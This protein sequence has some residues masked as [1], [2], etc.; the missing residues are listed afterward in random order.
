MGVRPARVD[1][2]TASPDEVAQHMQIEAEPEVLIACPPCTGFSRTIAQNHM[3]DDPRNNLVVRVADFAQAWRPRVIV[4]ENARELVMGRFQSHLENLAARLGH[5]GYKVEAKTYFLDRFGLPQ[6]RER[7]IVVAVQKSLPLLTLSELW[8]PWEV[9]VKATHVRRAIWHL[10]ELEA[11]AV[12]LAD[13]MHASPAFSSVTARARTGAI[14]RD[15]GSWFDIPE[16]RHDLLTPTMRDRLARGQLGSH[17]DVYGRMWW[18]RPAPTIKRE[19]SHVGNGRYTH[20]DQDR[21]CSVRE[22]ALLNGFPID[23][24]FEG[25][26]SNRYRH[27]GDAVPPMIAYQLA[28]V[29]KWSLT[30]ERPSVEEVVMPG[31]T[32]TPADIR[33]R[34]Q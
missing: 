14:P 31:T 23:Y 12:C 28:A 2:G 4:M 7:A 33:V 24:R 22:M 27:V 25:S 26:V 6:R 17:P 32:L 9:D 19:C 11:G 20:P 1:L 15:G 3:R 13:A 16:V 18:D 29:V 21:L 10:P 30:G 8:D 5:L 34:S